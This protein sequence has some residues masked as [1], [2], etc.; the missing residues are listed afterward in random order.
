MELARDGGDLS[1]GAATTERDDFVRR[2]C[3]HAAGKREVAGVAV[4][5]WGGEG[6]PK[7]R[8]MARGD[9]WI[10]DPPHEPQGW[11]SVYDADAATGPGRRE[12]PPHVDESVLSATVMLN[13]QAE[14]EGGGVWFAATG[15]AINA[16][17]GSVV[18]FAGGLRHGGLPG[19]RGTR[20]IV[21]LFMYSDVNAMSG[22][23]RGYT[24]E[25]LALAP[26]AGSRV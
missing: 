15:D 9:E 1:A 23:A 8:E 10:G 7:Q 16:D 12:L 26:A 25:E 14:Y 3:E 17:A 24:L 5:A 2:M 21:A 18:A 19:T 6:R 13:D 20:Y 4:W 22:R 11:Y